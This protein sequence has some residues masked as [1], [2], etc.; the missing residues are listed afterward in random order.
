M[1]LG[2]NYYC[3]EFDPDN[4]KYYLKRGNQQWVSETLSEHTLSIQY[5]IYHISANKLIP[6]THVGHGVVPP[7]L[8]K[9]MKLSSLVSAETR[10][11]YI[12]TCNHTM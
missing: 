8:I 10:P 6:P 7:Q 2:S 3:H 12:H 4:L 9:D 11:S 5:I 1:D